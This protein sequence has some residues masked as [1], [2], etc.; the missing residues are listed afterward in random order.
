MIPV[1]FIK[2]TCPYCPPNTDA[3]FKEV[4][5][6]GYRLFDC[7]KHVF[8]YDYSPSANP[9][10]TTCP[11][12]KRSGIDDGLFRQWADEQSGVCDIPTVKHLRWENK[13]LREGLEW[14]AQGN[15]IERAEYVKIGKVGDDAPDE[16]LDYGE[17]A[18]EILSSI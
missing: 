18:Q 16:I 11:T 17:H 10:A 5:P 9:D 12:C 6:S 15:H 13:R 2:V 3:L 1:E 14:Y 8:R 4:D 7:G